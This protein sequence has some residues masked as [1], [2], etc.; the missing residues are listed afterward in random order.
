MSS[1]AT[2]VMLGV[3]AAEVVKQLVRVILAAVTD[4]S[5]RP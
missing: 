1:F 4:R 2:D 3:L 5:E